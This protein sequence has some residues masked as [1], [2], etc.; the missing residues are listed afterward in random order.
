MGVQ[1]ARDA[2][3]RALWLKAGDG[4]G[5]SLCMVGLSGDP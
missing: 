4:A 3:I 5:W 1:A 2:L